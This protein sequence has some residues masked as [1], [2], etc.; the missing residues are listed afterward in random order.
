METYFELFPEELIDLV[1]QFTRKDSKSLFSLG[2]RYVNIFNKL[3]DKIKKGFIDPVIC[4]DTNY[5]F[6]SYNFLYP[7]QSFLD[8][9]G[10]WDYNGKSCVK[11]EFDPKV[12]ITTEDITNFKDLI[13]NKYSEIYYL[14]QGEND[15]DTWFIV[16]KSKGYYIYF[17]ASCCYTGFDVIGGG[18]FCFNKDWKTFWNMCTTNESRMMILLKNGYLI[19]D[20]DYII[21]NYY[22]TFKDTYFNNY[23]FRSTIKKLN[24]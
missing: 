24:L 14:Q 4:F 3:V 12:N 22:I 16:A 10:S 13:N 8:G 5:D 23:K 9:E 21:N 19:E 11:D 18:S 1:F 17:E 20:K 2:D 15:G 7:I 6:N